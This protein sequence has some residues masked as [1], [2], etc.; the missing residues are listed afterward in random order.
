MTGRDSGPIAARKTTLDMDDNSMQMA[1]YAI[2]C[3]LLVKTIAKN[4]GLGSFST[5]HTDQSY[6][7]SIHLIS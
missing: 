6:V 4:T 7:C 5:T 1:W 2:L 3:N